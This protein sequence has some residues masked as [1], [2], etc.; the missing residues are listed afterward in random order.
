MDYKRFVNDRAASLKPSGIRRFFDLVSE[1]KG[2][3]SLGVGEPDFAT[4]YVGRDRAVKYIN[5]GFTQYTPNGGYPELRELISA[6]YSRRYGLVYDPKTE[7]LVTVGA[8]EA[9]DLALRAVVSYGDEVLLPDPSYVSYLPCVT[10]SGAV[11]VTVPCSEKNGFRLTA[12]AL[13]EKI[14]AGTKV[15]ILPYPNNP[16]GG[17]LERADLEA[18]AKVCIER[19]ILVISDEI[20]SELTYTESG[21]VSIASIPGMRERTVVINGFSK[22]FAMTGWRLGYLLCPPELLSPMYKIHQYT[23]MCAPTASQ[24]AAIGVLRQS[25]EDDFASVKEMRS[26][27]DMRRRY[28]VNEF[29]EMG[30]HCFEPEGAFYVFPSV[31]GTGMDG[32]A[33][34]ET[35]LEQK[36][37]AVVPGSAFGEG[38]KYFVRVSY[39][40]SMKNLQKAV[41]LIR[42]FLSERE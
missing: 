33:F 11:P 8:S 29:N 25:L 37:G 13:E 12:K 14:T 38:G 22:A 41:G 15:L 34:A 4:P 6:Y 35:L 3:I 36:N 39:A 28:L 40:Y 23:I 7:I 32:E 16:T 26:Q 17:I 2:A 9:I 20:Y 1:K 19:D 10:M 24:H 5:K 42:E 27:Y 30:L 18:I 21:H 31:E